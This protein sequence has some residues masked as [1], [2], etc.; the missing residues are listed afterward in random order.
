MFTF[1]ADG[2]SAVHLDFI[3]EHAGAVMDASPV[4]YIANA[5]L[6]G[7]LF[8]T[9]EAKGVVSSVDTQFFVDHAEPLEALAC[10]REGI[11]WPLGELLEGYEFLF[12]LKARRRGRSSKKD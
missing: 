4:D 2:L 9:E 8:D 7:S 11:D 10:I 12:L 3:R 5:G 1:I 6:R